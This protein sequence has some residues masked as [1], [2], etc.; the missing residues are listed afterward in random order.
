MLISIKG[1]IDAAFDL[2]DPVRAT[3]ARSEGGGAPLTISSSIKWRLGVS[4]ASAEAGPGCRDLTVDT[5][6]SD[7]D[8]QP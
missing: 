1:I 6:S 4:R 8:L 5:V 7:A 2:S 3:A